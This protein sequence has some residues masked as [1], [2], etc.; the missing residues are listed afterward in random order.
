MGYTYTMGTYIHFAVDGIVTKPYHE[1][2][3]YATSDLMSP[4]HMYIPVLLKSNVWSVEIVVAPPKEVVEGEYFS[5][6]P[7]IRVLDVNGNPVEGQMVIA[8]K[9]GSNNVL[10]PSFYEHIALGKDG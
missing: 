5:V 9:L 1:D 4:P 8:M 10:N 2:L 7:V 3:G 6:Q